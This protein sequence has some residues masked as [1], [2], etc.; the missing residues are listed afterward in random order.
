VRELDVF[1]V[2]KTASMAPRGIAR[3]GPRSSAASVRV[4]R[5]ISIPRYN[6]PGDCG[7]ANATESPGR[8]A[9]LRWRF[10]GSSGFVDA[11]GVTRRCST[12]V[13]IDLRMR[14]HTSFI[15]GLPSRQRC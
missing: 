14:D 15:Q 12:Q 13:L 2:M 5:R 7:P 11:A 3:F 9:G 1:T 8:F 4:S 6:E 10:L